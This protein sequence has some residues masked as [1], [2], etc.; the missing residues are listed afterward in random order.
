ML[1][2]CGCDRIRAFLQ[3]GTDLLRPLTPDSAPLPPRRTWKRLCAERKPSRT[4]IRSILQRH[5]GR[6]LRRMPCSGSSDTLTPRSPR[7]R[8]R[9]LLLA[10]IGRDWRR[11][12]GTPRSRRGCPRTRC[13]AAGDLRS[14]PGVPSV[15]HRGR[16]RHHYQWNSVRVGGVDVDRGPVHC[17]LDCK[18]HSDGHG[19]VNCY[20]ASD[21]TSIGR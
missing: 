21:V 6:W 13:G 5:W 4:P 1:S 14:C 2:R 16:G 11:L 8:L 7:A 9:S 12:H 19:G 18:G 10:R 15:R 20:E 3:P 17:A